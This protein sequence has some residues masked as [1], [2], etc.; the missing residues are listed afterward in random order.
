MAVLRC[1]LRCNVWFFS[2]YN[3]STTK[4]CCSWKL[5]PEKNFPGQTALNS[6]VRELLGAREK[7]LFY[8]SG[9]FTERNCCLLSLK[10]KLLLITGLDCNM[11]TCNADISD[12]FQA[13]AGWEAGRTGGSRRAAGVGVRLGRLRHSH[14]T[15]TRLAQMAWQRRRRCF[16]PLRSGVK[17]KEKCFFRSHLRVE[18]AANCRV[19][20]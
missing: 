3:S 18:L 10:W 16:I 14:Q 12:E 19:T 20:L 9:N 11:M 8:N 4:C 1:Y 17:N 7:H 13:G 5:T 15:P 6:S 2:L